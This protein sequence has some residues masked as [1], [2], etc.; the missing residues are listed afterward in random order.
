MKKILFSFACAVFLFCS[1]GCHTS[2]SSAQSD[3]IS[4]PKDREIANKIFEQFRKERKTSAGDLMVKVGTFF[5]G[6]PY[7]AH[8]LE[9][10]KDEKMVINLRE[11]D[12][13]TFVENCLALTRT[14][15]SGKADF[16]HFVK[17][18]E[19]IRYRKGIRNGY[20]SRLH[21][22][23]DW[24]YENEQKKIILNVS[25]DIA[26]TIMPNRVSFMSTHPESYPV[27]AGDLQMIK[28]IA[29]REVEISERM[30]W[31]IPKIRI[32]EL[33]DQLK[34]GDI[35]AFT[36][37]IEGLDISHVSIAVRKSGHV[38]FLHAS[39]KFNKVILSEETLAEYLTGSKMASG[40]M[41][42][43]PL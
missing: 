13:T 7:V 19:Y 43:R 24:I 32:A 18:L 6:T 31:Y 39:S 2:E 17:E 40:I 37:H 38:K 11:L 35:I 36:T 23:S 9:K 28:E 15:R 20:P 26:H 41:V 8:T 10:G 27:L 12:C 1:D 14:I 30:T 25:R 16:E 42:A 33:E 22:F 3:W 5:L 34:D 4:D 29:A 21:Y